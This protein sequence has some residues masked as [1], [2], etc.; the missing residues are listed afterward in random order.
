VRI[1]YSFRISDGTLLFDTSVS[2]SVF[3]DFHYSC[4]FSVDP[5][6]N[7]ICATPSMSAQL[8][9]CSR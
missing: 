4:V 1:V 6:S 3:G 7:A 2:H 9:S 8:A 5:T